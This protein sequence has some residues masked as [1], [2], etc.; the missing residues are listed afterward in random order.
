MFDSIV[1]GRDSLADVA[2]LGQF[3]ECL[4]YYQRVHAV[5]DHLSFTRLARICGPETLS[6]LIEDG[7]LSITYQENRPAVKTRRIGGRD[8]HEFVLIRGKGTE[9]QHLVPKLFQELTGKQ[10]RGRR[11]ASRLLSRT[12]TRRYERTD[13]D[14]SLHAIETASYTDRL[15]PQLLVAI[16]ISDM[17][18]EMKFRVHK[19]TDSFIV[20]TNLDF[21]ALSAD[22]KSYHHGAPLTAAH[23]LALLYGG[24]VEVDFAASLAVEMAPTPTESVIA[25]ERVASVLEAS[26]Q[27]VDRLSAFREFAIPHS[28]SIAESINSGRRSFEDLRKLLCKAARFKEWVGGQPPEVD[29]AKAYVHE[30]TK[31]SWRT[32]SPTENL[33]FLLFNAAQIAAGAAVTG[34]L[35]LLADVALAAT[36]RYLLDRILKGWRPDQFVCRPLERFL[37]ASQ[38]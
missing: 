17:Q 37:R 34:P 3:A 24:Y 35:K 26:G 33:R 13:L 4:L 20:D 30:I 8:K 14:Q 19:E 21:V 7:H 22:H 10:G 5:V 38:H 12:V 23:I 2:N 9:S 28:G 6:G 15:V 32:D 36:D 11:L 29:L 18:G 25:K 16:G 1:F 27:S 31:V